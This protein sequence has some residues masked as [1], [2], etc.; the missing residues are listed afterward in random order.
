MCKSGFR[1]ETRSRA[2]N[3]A[4]FGLKNVERHGCFY[5]R[6]DAWIHRLLVSTDAI[7]PNDRS[8]HRTDANGLAGRK[9]SSR[10]NLD[11]T[12]CSSGRNKN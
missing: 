2:Q 9:I 7:G 4:R 11:C 5:F 10:N 8:I 1:D 6:T 12:G 3:A